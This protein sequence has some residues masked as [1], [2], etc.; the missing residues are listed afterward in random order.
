MKLSIIRRRVPLGAVLTVKLRSGETVIGALLAVE[1]D[2]CLVVEVDQRESLILA[3]TIEKI[4]YSPAQTEENTANGAA[5][6]MAAPAGAGSLAPAASSSPPLPPA[7]SFPSPNGLA[8]PPTAVVAAEPVASEVSTPPG[9]APTAP[10]TPEEP[11]T[12]PAPPGRV[13]TASPPHAE[14]P[15]TE[16]PGAEAPAAHLDLLRELHAKLAPDVQDAQLV[17]AAPD[18]QSLPDLKLYY[19]LETVLVNDV[20]KRWDQARS[21]YAYATRNNLYERID[22]CAAGI[23]DL[24]AKY[25]YLAEGHALLGALLYE[26]E[27]VAGCG[28]E[29]SEAVALEYEPALC[30]LAAYHLLTGDKA[31]ARH[32]LA[33]Y[34]ARTSPADDPQA[35]LMMLKLVV[36][37]RAFG[38]LRHVA[39]TVVAAGR[40]MNGSLANGVGYV[41]VEASIP[42]SPELQRRLAIAAG[43][44]DRDRAAAEAL[45]GIPVEA[46]RPVLV[47]SGAGRRRTSAASGWAQRKAPVAVPQNVRDARRLQEQA[48]EFA[49]HRQHGQ[50]INLIRQ[51]IALDPANAALKRLEEEWVAESRHSAVPSGNTPFA[52]AERAKLLH[53]DYA[54]AERFYRQAIETDDRPE[55][56]AK[57]LASLLHQ[58]HRSDKALAVL[59]D[60]ESWHEVANRTQFDN[61]VADI[62]AHSGNIDQAVER[63]TA[64]LGRTPRQNHPPLLNRLATVYA[65]DR[66]YDE[67]ERKLEQSLQIAP[68]DASA[69]RLL[70]TLVQARKTGVYSEVDAMVKA[71]FADVRN[72]SFSPVLSFD[73]D[74]CEYDSVDAVKKSTK[75]FELRDVDRAESFARQ[76]AKDARAHDRAGANLSAARILID[77]G[78]DDLSRIRS[79]LRFYSAA[80]GDAM[81]ADHKPFEAIRTY[82][83][84]ALT[85]SPKWEADLLGVKLR[86]FLMTFYASSPGDVLDPA[87]L[88]EALESALRT[89]RRQ[90]LASLLP[91]TAKSV[92]LQK[93]VVNAA[94]YTKTL[95]AQVLDGLRED[96]GIE[97]PQTGRDE[98]DFVNAWL[99]AI[100]VLKRR[101][102]ETDQ[103]FRF[104]HEQAGDLSTLGQQKNTLD[105]IQQSSPTALES[106]L[107]RDAADLLNVVREYTAQ[108]KYLE[109]ERLAKKTDDSCRQLVRLAEENRTQLTIGGLL[110]Y[111]LRLRKAV[112][113]HFAEVE[114][115]AEPNELDTHLIVDNVSLPDDGAVGVQLAVKNRLGHSPA[116]RVRLELLLGPD[117]VYTAQQ[118]H[119]PVTEAL[120]AGESEP[121]TIPI[122]VAPAARSEH[123]VTLRTRVSFVTR[124]GH[125]VV[126]EETLH[127]LQLY[128]KDD[129]K[130]FANPYSAGHP[131]KDPNMLFGRDSLIAELAEAIQHTGTK[132][133]VIYGQKRTGKTS[134]S[135]HLKPRLTL[136]IVP[137]SF[138]I[139]DI[140]ADLGAD[141]HGFASFFFRV[142]RTV[143]DAVEKLAVGRGIPLDVP[144]PRLADIRELPQGALIDFMK[145]VQRWLTRF[146]DLADVRFVLLIDEFTNIYEEIRKRNLPDTFMKAWKGLLE[147]GNFSALVIGQDLTQEFMR[148]YPNEFQVS[149]VERVNYLSRE[150]ARKLIEDPIRIGGRQGPTRYQG[151]SVDMILDLTAGNPFY[152]QKFCERLVNY[153]NR[154][155][156]MYVGPADVKAVRDDLVASLHDTTDFDNLLNPGDVRL[157]AIPPKKVI[158]TLLACSRGFGASRY[159]DPTTPEAG[160]LGWDVRLILDDLQLRDVIEPLPP[161]R[162]RIRVGLFARWL[163]VNYA[164]RS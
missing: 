58:I 62:A 155:S 17:P 81:A 94:A 52:L 71:G 44:A 35:W 34:L 124:T 49:R 149:R 20:R 136:P 122:V 135:D 156:R 72:D 163:Q 141:N 54:A 120:G 101:A 99:T 42:V 18:F 105:R 106:R 85:V 89:S 98:E 59:R 67:A 28:E 125:E 145:L 39:D 56:A 138:S 142:A 83:Q 100:D 38:L 36:S 161:D 130:G 73:L 150:D 15:G 1:D 19:D 109:Q 157:S 55:S 134:I 33:A 91:V 147:Q 69:K 10:T 148:N 113:D 43:P 123:V 61:V 95:R 68:D 129:F 50:A 132:S 63:L 77:I 144:E 117:D 104:L 24:L 46:A 152:I 86:Q 53:R 25:P 75:Q 8:A 57:N 2:D 112:R 76:R 111:V 131:V 40:G 11:P 115:A 102:E 139:N 32:S 162:W 5:P 27:D 116:S 3:E 137:V 84:E 37:G 127:G 103:N 118:R 143:Y 29:F 158:D 48:E 74:R 6:V 4:D 87:P 31:A 133:I 108:Q 151:N 7:A 160:L 65:R 22:Y 13:A 96:I 45:A 159:L 92:D 41:V 79:N 93:L 97:L 153:L 60:Y 128:S 47:P 64:M 146:D 164:S 154:G 51:A 114:S 88:R 66:R 9:T 80:M 126:S 90:L 14:A 26:R 78:S 119:F 23:R 140:I 21:R 107:L 121:L 30:D 70:D 12:A 110:P 82:Y 16:T